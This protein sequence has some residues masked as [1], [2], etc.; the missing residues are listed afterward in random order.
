MR[1]RV[2]LFRGWSRRTRHVV[3]RFAL[4][5]VAYLVAAVLAWAMLAL[6]TGSSTSVSAG[7]GRPTVVTHT[8]STLY[9]EQPGV[10]RVILAA[11]VVT[12]LVATASVVWRVARRSTGTG[13]TGMIV[14]GLVAVAAVGGILTIG[15]FIAPLAVLLVLLARPIGPERPVAGGERPDAPPGW[16]GDPAGSGSWRWWDGHRWTAATA[17]VS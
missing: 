11:L 4:L 13:V 7:T 16:Y 15:M 8:T 6:T 5:E 1:P 10:V 12:L 9:Q 2:V 17:P 14:G 3:A